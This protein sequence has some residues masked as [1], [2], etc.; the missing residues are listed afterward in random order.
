ME[1]KRILLTVLILLVALGMAG[2][3]SAAP[4]GTAFTYQGRL[5]D[6]NE[7]ATG[8][9]FYEFEFKV[10]DSVSDGNQVDGTFS[11]RSVEVVD[12]YFTVQLDFGSDTFRGDARWLQVGVRPID[13]ADPFVT[14]SPRQ[15]LTPTPYALYAGD[16]G[17]WI[18][19]DSDMYSSA[20][21]NVGIGTQNPEGKLEV[22]GGKAFEGTSGTDLVFKAQDGGDG[23]AMQNDGAPGGDIILMPGEGGQEIGGGSPGPDGNV[24]IGTTS[25]RTKLEV[26]STTGVRVTTG[27]HSNVYGDFKHAYSGGLIINAHAGGGGWADMSLQT[28]ATT[29]MFIESGGNIGV[30]T[31]SPQTKLHIEG[32]SDASIGGGGFLVVGSVSSTN[33]VID[34]NEIIARN[35]G[36]P[37]KLYLNNDGDNVVVDVLEITGGSDLAEPFEVGGTESIEAGMVVAIDPEQAGQLVVS[38]EAYDR[39]VAGIISGAGGIQPGMLMGQKDSVATGTN[40]VALTGRVYCLADATYGA[41]QPGDLLTTSQTPGHAMKVTDFTK[42]NG[43]ILGKAMSSLDEGK[44]L[45]LVL[46]TLQ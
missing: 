22:D 41:I 16:D 5:A 19:S 46:V 1:S 45:V 12:G 21:G 3:A 14:L 43:A 24:G 40:P 6:A 10:Y 25:P 44:G 33:V 18:S 31:T 42:A 11:L 15:E 35:N 23:W 20:S 2:V 28:N 37:A 26:L 34:N 4:M 32:G 38:S 39:K 13:T 7:S 9:G 30:G 8:F 36:A 29:R 17:D 27:E